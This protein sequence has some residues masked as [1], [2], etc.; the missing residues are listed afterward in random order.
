MNA[1]ASG[2]TT[3]TKRGN[4][5]GVASV[6]QI[7]FES[8]KGWNTRTQP[9]DA[10]IAEA[11]QRCGEPDDAHGVARRMKSCEDVQAHI[12]DPTCDWCAEI[13]REEAEWE[14]ENPP[15]E[16]PSFDYDYA[17]GYAR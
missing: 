1:A 6:W 5:D 4:G 9:M 11:R 12:G 3:E 16:E 17:N 7:E 14:R 8:G 10:A 15:Q 13:R 2:P